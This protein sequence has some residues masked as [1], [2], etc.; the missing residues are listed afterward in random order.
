MPFKSQEELNK[1]MKA[2]PAQAKRHISNAKKMGKPV[3][4]SSNP[5]YRE[6]IK[7]RLQKSSMPGDEGD[8]K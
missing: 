3:V 2:D 8:Y 1:M 5:G 7:R 4:S 6:A